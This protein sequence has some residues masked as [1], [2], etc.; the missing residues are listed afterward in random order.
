MDQC[1]GSQFHT[2]SVSDKLFL[3][4][5]TERGNGKETAQLMLARLDP[6]LDHTHIYMH[7]LNYFLGMENR[8]L[9]S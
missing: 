9:I 2:D 7:I 3:K 1:L 4:L 5:A 6:T 8:K